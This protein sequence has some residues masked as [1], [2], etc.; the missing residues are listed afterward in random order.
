MSM[1]RSMAEDERGAL[2]DQASERLEEM[3][4]VRQS[5]N[6]AAWQNPL[7][8][9][10]RYSTRRWVMAGSDLVSCLDRMANEH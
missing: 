7:A 8:E 4:K 10:R 3:Q 5:S 1:R 9:R 2:K 6:D